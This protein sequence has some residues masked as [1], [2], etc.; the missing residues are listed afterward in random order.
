MR[1]GGQTGTVLVLTIRQCENKVT[2][3]FLIT[4]V[5]SQTLY[6]ERNFI[7]EISGIVDFRYDH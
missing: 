7:T 5:L 1:N 2:N 6:K 3:W 4:S